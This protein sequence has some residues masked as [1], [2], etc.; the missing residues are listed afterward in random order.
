MFGPKEAR[1]SSFISRKTTEKLLDRNQIKK[2][3]DQRLL[4]GPVQNLGDL[5]AHARK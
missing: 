4:V 2:M 5:E 1:F 3:T